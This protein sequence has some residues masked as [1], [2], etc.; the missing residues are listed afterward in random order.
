[1]PTKYPHLETERLVVF[2]PAPRLAPGMVEYY[3]RNRDHLASWEPRRS[4]EFW[5]VEWWA[6]QLEYNQR[7]FREDRGARM[8]V[9]L[10]SD[11]DRI[12]GVANLSNTVRGSFQA[13]YLGYSIDRELQ[14]QGYMR[15]ALVAVIEFAFDE[16]RLHRVMANYQPQNRRS[17]QLLARLGFVR[18][19]YARNYLRI[20]GSWRDHVL[21]ARTNPSWD[22]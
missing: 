18:E 11:P 14:G 5:T 2:L 1:M 22:H 19:G 21:T 7:E 8:I 16:L 9:A 15:E 10:S 13:C 4:S 12:V 6:R 17:G 3:R 20:D